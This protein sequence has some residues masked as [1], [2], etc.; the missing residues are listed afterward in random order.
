[1]ELEY[2]TRGEHEE[3]AKRISDEDARQNKRLS[4][5]E[6]ALEQQN[7]LALSVEKMAVNMEQ[8]L[9]EQQ[10]QGERLEALEQVPAKNWN[11]I[12]VAVLSAI[13]GALGTGIVAG[14]VSLL[15]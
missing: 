11:T 5:I 10:K 13:G 2:I 7:K 9:K 1:M 8:M 6:K 14:I 15:S 12:R 4:T 3:F